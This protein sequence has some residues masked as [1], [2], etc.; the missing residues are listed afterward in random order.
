MRPLTL[1]LTLACACAHAPARD[2][3]EALPPA[4][5]VRVDALFKPWSRPDRPGCVV[6]VQQGAERVLSRAYGMADL[7]HGVPN[8]LDTVFEAGSVSKQYTA[9]ALLL[10]VAEGKLDLDAPVSGLFPELQGDTR[11]ATWRQVLHHTSGLRDFGELALLEGWPRGTR[12][13]RMADILRIT[14]RQ[15][16]LNFAPGTDYS[17]S[18]SNYTLAALAVERLSQQSLA[19]FTQARLFGP[20]GLT[21]TGWRTDFRAVVPGRAQAYEVKG[22]AVLLAMPVEHCIGNGGLLTT[23]DDLLR[24]AGRYRSPVTDGLVKQQLE[25]A[26]LSNGAV[27]TYGLGIHVG[28]F[29]G[30][31]EVSHEG[32]T[33][34]YRSFLGVYP[35]EDVAVA[36]LCNSADAWPGDLARAVVAPYLKATLPPEAPEVPPLQGP[37]VYH[38]SEATHAAV[39]V[40]TADGK[41]GLVHGPALEPAGPHAFRAGDDRCLWE[42][43]DAEPASFVRS[44][45]GRAREVFHAMP[46]PRPVADI[47]AELVGRY[48]S[49]EANASVELTWNQHDLVLTRGGEPW[50]LKPLYLDG[51]KLPEGQLRVLRG[52]QG[53][54]TGL[55]FSASRAW[56]V[57]FDRVR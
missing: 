12:A 32:A 33:A 15:Q 51:F 54:V 1:V 38:R 26:T 22:D 4:E 34:G 30:H 28:D 21:H 14:A 9:A 39:G 40:V 10:L 27:N 16:G 8:T 7:E 18:N 52:P 49:D 5:A 20:L 46:P 35:Q 2:P 25:P 55:G 45:E 11:K 6:A 44:C 57:R 48:R 42:I 3:R 31:R 43:N 50:V 13:L 24:W 53:E 37:A 36:L 29:L 56:D 47:Q 17:Y 41:R 23:V 19:D